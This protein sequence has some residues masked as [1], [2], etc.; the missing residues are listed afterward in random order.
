MIQG[1]ETASMSLHVTRPPRVEPVF[2]R[3]S[4]AFDDAPSIVFSLDDRNGNQ[5]M[6]AWALI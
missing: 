4:Y 2:S 1:V 6:H 3:Q 5:M